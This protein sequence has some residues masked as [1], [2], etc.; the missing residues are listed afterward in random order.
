MK[1]LRKLSILAI[2]TVF[3]ARV[4]VA[5]G[6]DPQKQPKKRLPKPPADNSN[7]ILPLFSLEIKSETAIAKIGEKLE[8]EVTM[9]NT[10]SQ[11]IFYTR[12]QRDFGLEVR[13]ETG[14]KIARVPTAANLRDG[15]S[16]A[17]RL[18]P[19]ESICWHARLDKEF[20]LDQPGNYFVQATRGISETKE[21]KSNTIT[22]TMVP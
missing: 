7:I 3:L 4:G 6:Q 16:F 21:R 5:N 12:P 22:I 14:R 20:D 15:S 18:H 11:D 19:G 9:T 8:I 10:D 2:T 17:A 13:D 1:M